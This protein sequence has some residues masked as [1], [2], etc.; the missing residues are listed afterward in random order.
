MAADT[1]R[2]LNGIEAIMKDLADLRHGWQP[3]TG[4]YIQRGTAPPGR[5]ANDAEG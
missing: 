2:V 3:D 5:N 4:F 1:R